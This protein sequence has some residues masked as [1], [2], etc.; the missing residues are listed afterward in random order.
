MTWDAPDRT[1]ASPAS[2]TTCGTRDRRSAFNR[3]QTMPAALA[4]VIAAVQAD[5]VVLSYNNDHG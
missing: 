3:R 1:T 2:A 5:V 4:G